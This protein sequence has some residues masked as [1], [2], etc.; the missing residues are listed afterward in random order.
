MLQMKI[1]SDT[2]NYNSVHTI[3]IFSASASNVHKT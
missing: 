1:P 2:G 3:L